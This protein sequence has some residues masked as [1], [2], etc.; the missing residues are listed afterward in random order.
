MHWRAMAVRSAL[1]L[2]SDCASFVTPLLLQALLG[3]LEAGDS[4]GVP[5]MLTSQ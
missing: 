5:L 4:P 3:C 1:L 2:L